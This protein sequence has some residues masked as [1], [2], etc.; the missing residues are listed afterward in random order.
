MILCIKQLNDMKASSAQLKVKFME[1]NT[2]AN[3]TSI[4]KAIVS[5]L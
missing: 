3:N 1:T 5:P 4:N 2:F